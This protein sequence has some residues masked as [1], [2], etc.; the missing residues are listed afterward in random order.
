MQTATQDHPTRDALVDRAIG[1]VDQLAG[2]LAEDSPRGVPA[3]RREGVSLAHSA[4]GALAILRLQ[5]DSAEAG[6]LSRRAD[7]L[8]EASWALPAIAAA[9]LLATGR[10]GADILEETGLTPSDFIGAANW[11]P[12]L[13]LER[14]GEARA[15]VEGG[16]HA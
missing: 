7:L 8:R 11:I 2:M 6:Q 14:Y 4:L 5:A 3:D 12:L 9:A 13:V 16:D 10:Y 15:K 1:P